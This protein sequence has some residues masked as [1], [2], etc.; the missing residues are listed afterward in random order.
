MDT[1]EP[2]EWYKLIRRRLQDNRN[3]GMYGGW[4]ST[5]RPPYRELQ[6]ITFDT[7]YNWSEY[8]ETEN[9]KRQEE[10]EQYFREWPL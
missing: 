9:A 3:R 6:D 8:D 4:Y 5:Y 10:M 7:Q 2:Q 1:E